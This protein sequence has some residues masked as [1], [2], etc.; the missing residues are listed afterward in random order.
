MRVLFNYSILTLYTEYEAVNQLIMQN[1][2][3]VQM[4]NVIT[5]FNDNHVLETYSESELLSRA[6]HLVN[7]MN[8]LLKQFKSKN[9]Y[10]VLDGY[11]A[12]KVQRN[13]IYPINEDNQL[14]TAKDMMMHGF[15]TT[16]RD[17]ISKGYITEAAYR[18]RE[19]CEDFIALNFF[20]YEKG[21]PTT[22][23][24]PNELTDPKV[25]LSPHCWNMVYR[26]YN[27]E[28]YYEGYYDE[29]DEEDC[30]NN[31]VVDDILSTKLYEYWLSLGNTGTKREFTQLLASLAEKD[32]R[33]L[34]KM[35]GK[36]NGNDFLF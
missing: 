3:L 24:D 12:I 30:D 6:E 4:H 13:K 36:H 2:T 16:F 25:Q 14:W 21:K 9:F 26:S 27:P 35:F 10:F 20:L 31:Q 5:K 17:Y 23:L 34:L 19:I 11:Y 22:F 29:E 1:R 32:V 8:E 33:A 7:Q 18:N 15:D 28:D